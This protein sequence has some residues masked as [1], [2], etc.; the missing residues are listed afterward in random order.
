M[1]FKTK[2]RASYIYFLDR[3][4][5]PDPRWLYGVLGALHHL[6]GWCTAEGNTFLSA[7]THA[8]CEVDDEGDIQPESVAFP[9]AV[10]LQWRGQYQVARNVC[11]RCVDVPRSVVFCPFLC[12]CSTVGSS[13]CRYDLGVC[14]FQRLGPS[15]AKTKFSSHLYYLSEE[16]I[17]LHPEQSGIRRSDEKTPDLLRRSPRNKNRRFR[18]NTYF[19]FLQDIRHRH[20]LLLRTIWDVE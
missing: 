13:A 9:I 16:L 5:R 20:R 8:F 18:D 14:W 6:F 15:I 11:F 3:V 4:D 19:E 10:W 2:V 12:I 17:G 1:R 7:R